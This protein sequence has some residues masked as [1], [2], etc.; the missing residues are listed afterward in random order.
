MGLL[1][2]GTADPLSAG[3]ALL[4]MVSAMAAS[5]PLVVLVDDAQWGDQLSLRALSLAGGQGAE[6]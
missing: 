3:S 1:D 2:P 4:G 6:P 5:E